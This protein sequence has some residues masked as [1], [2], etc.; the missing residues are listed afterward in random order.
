MIEGI[1]EEKHELRQLLKNGLT[2]DRAHAEMMSYLRP[3]ARKA[4][5]SDPLIRHS[6]VIMLLFPTPMGR[7][8]VF[9]ARQE[10][11]GVHSGQIGF[12]GGKAEPDD[13]NLSHTALREM[14]EEIGVNPGDVDV[15]GQL[16]EVYIPPSHFLVSPFVG[17]MDREPAFIPDNREV[18]ELLVQPLGPLLRPG[19]VQTSPVHLPAY[20]TTLQVPSFNIHGH[21]LWGATAM[22]LHE[23]RTTINPALLLN[24]LNP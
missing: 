9:I 2:G 12:P 19:I 5:T 15:V 22:M 16:S 17:W 11:K 3:A 7:S 8:T 24:P 21:I 1:P 6:A 4:R 23:F 20:N 18:R 14:E 13:D 10:Y